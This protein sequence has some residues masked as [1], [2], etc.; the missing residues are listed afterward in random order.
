MDY[1]YEQEADH[2]HSNQGSLMT[3]QAAEWEIVI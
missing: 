1:D 3:D 2:Y